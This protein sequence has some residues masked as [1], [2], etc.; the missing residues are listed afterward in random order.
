MTSESSSLHK[1]DGIQNSFSRHESLD[2]PKHS[3]LQNR[4][5]DGQNRLIIC[6]IKFFF[7]IISI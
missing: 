3:P 7:K 5:K 6:S 1:I 4:E 2:Q